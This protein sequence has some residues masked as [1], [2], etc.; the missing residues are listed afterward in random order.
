MLQPSCI[1]VQAI[2][3]HRAAGPH[4]S[5]PQVHGTPLALPGRCPRRVVDRR[6]EPTMRLAHVRFIALVAVVLLTGVA[7]AAPGDYRI[8]SGTLVW[9]QFLTDE[10]LVVVR[11]DDGVTYFAE[12]LGPEGLPSVRVGD[13]VAVVGRDAMQPG[14]LVSARVSPIADGGAS[15]TIDGGY[16]SA[17]PAQATS[18]RRP[19]PSGV[20]PLE[21]TAQAIF[22]TVDSLTGSMLNVVADGQ[23]VS[24]DVSAIDA[25][26]RS[27]LVSGQ[28]VRVLAVAGAGRLVAQGVVLEPRTAPTAPARQ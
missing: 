6:E 25:D 7:Q 4:A 12:L 10:G 13:R 11:G 9:P 23:P 8:V 18:A 20:V 27:R 24:V 15:S 21:G 1:T 22:G 28:G 26:V 3:A 5:A 16:P 14:Q 19:P 2:T 17:S